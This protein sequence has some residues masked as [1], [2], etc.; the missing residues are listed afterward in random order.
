MRGYGKT[1]GVAALEETSALRPAA[2][3]QQAQ[4]RIGQLNTGIES[5][6]ASHPGTV[7]LQPAIDAIDQEIAKATSQNNGQAIEQL[8]RV[9]DALTKG[10][11]TGNP[12]AVDQSAS[13]A[14]NMKRG[15]RNQFIKNWNPE[16]M[17]GTRAVA[18]HASGAIDNSLDQA[19]G[20]EFQSANQK[21][22]SLIPVAER[23]ESLEREPSIAQKVGYRLTRPTGA[24]IGS[25]AG[26]AEGYREHGLPGAIGGGLLGLVLPEALGSAPAQMAAAR[27]MHN[28]GALIRLL[29]GSGLQFNRPS[30][31]NP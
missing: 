30:Q 4:Q 23:S 19:L 21:I 5:S 2:L 1:P 15:L 12:L 27:V 20:P 31:E 26:S 14:L 11:I 17:E 13:N 18:A 9:R 10:A 22:S 28:P 6:A 24:L 29:Q 16:L 8:G 3:E 7:S 25:V